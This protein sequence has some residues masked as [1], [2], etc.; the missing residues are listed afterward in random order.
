MSNDH[1]EIQ[2][3]RGMH[4]L[5]DVDDYDRVVD[6]G[7]W[8][9]DPAKR[10][11][12]ARKNLYTPGTQKLTPLLMHTFIT[13]WPYVDHINGDG[14]DNRRSNLRP[15]TALQN[16][17]NK[18]RY[19]NNTSGFKGVTRNSG[20]GRPWQASIRANNRRYH[21]GYHDTPEQAAR[22]YDAAALRLFGEFARPNFPRENYA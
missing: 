22:A 14:L 11:F 4:A 20:T 16:M 15:A 12:Y 3:S 9:A 13:G 6:M 2:L 18:R 1:K 21:L 5:V 17:A 7:S 10:T 19:R 8:C